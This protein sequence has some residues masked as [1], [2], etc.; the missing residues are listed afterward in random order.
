MAKRDITT[1]G[2][3]ML[4]KKSE[5]VTEFD[6]ELQILIKDMFETMRSADGVG[7]AA[8]QVGIPKRLY[9]MHMPDENG[10][11]EKGTDYVVINPEVISESV[12]KQTDDE[13]CLSVPGFQAEVTRPYRVKMKA[14]NEKG[15]EIILTGRGLMARAMLHEYDHTNGILFID[16]T[17]PK[18]R[19]SLKDKIEAIKEKYPNHIRK[20]T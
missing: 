9:V 15:E 4:S 2:N 16:R 5:D 12:R 18:I 8:V 11:M 17:T 13:G 6:E 14:Q 3:E 10:N 7:L 19:E 1:Y 20:L